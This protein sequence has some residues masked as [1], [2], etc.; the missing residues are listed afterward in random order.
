MNKS[1][2]KFIGLI[3]FFTTY[4][5]SSPFKTL[6]ERVTSFTSAIEIN[7]DGTVDIEEVIIYDTEGLQKHG[8]VR[9]LD[10]KRVNEDKKTYITDIN[11]LKI[12]DENDNPYN[13]Q[14][15]KIGKYIELKI[16]DADK[17]IT[18]IKTYVIKYKISGALTYFSD[19]DEL[20]WNL[21]GNS[22]N[23]PIEKYSALITLPESVVREETKYVCYTGPVGSTTQLCEIDISDNVLNISSNKP[24]N[25]GDGITVGVSFSKGAVEVIEPREDK[26]NIIFI[27]LW[28]ILG[29]LASLWYVFL[30]IKVLIDSVKKENFNKKERKNYSSSKVICSVRR[31]KGFATAAGD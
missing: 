13:Y 28:G 4:V 20:Y 30:P 3:C 15:A 31:C 29:L 12:T 7:K 16:G 18:G 26:S 19:H 1:I 10:F 22:W 14:K 17:F 27:I 9:N 8:L 24:L 25:P 11:I 21:T 5:F 23:F 6:A 2:I